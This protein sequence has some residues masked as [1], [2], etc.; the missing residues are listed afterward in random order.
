MIIFA[1][2]SDFP[3]TY[4]NNSASDFTV[5]LLQR[6]NFSPNSQVALL[7]II[8]PPSSDVKICYIYCSIVTYTQCNGSWRRVLRVIDIQQ[9]SAPEKFYFVKPIYFDIYCNNFEDIRFTLKDENNKTI[10][11]AS[12]AKTVIVLE[13]KNGSV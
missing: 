13:V 7:E 5:S 8:V 3:K 1:Q 6:E 12:G 4:P 2:S 11:F 9:N 10:D